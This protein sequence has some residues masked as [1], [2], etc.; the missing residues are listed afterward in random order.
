LSNASYTELNTT[1]AATVAANM[2]SNDFA[3][4]TDAQIATTVLTNL[5]LTTIAGLDNWVA[6]QLTAAGSTAAAK[7]A[8]LVSML[9][10]Y[11]MMTADA[12]YGASATSFNAKTEASLVKSQTTGTKSGSFATADVVALSTDPFVLTTGTDVADTVSATRGTLNS[13]F[14]FT[15]GNDT[16]NASIG[17]LNAADVLLDN[18]STDADVLNVTLN[19]DAGEFTAQSIETIAVNAAA[20]SPVIDMTKVFGTTAVTVSGNVA[21]Q[22]KDMDASIAGLTISASNYSK[23]LTVTP[24]TLVGTTALSTAETVNIKISGATF[25]TTTATQSA[26]VI[27]AGA[28]GTLET[29]N[30][31]SDGTAV[32]TFSLAT[33]ANGALGTVNL[34]G[35][36]DATV[37]VT[38]ADITGVTVAG[39]ANTANT[40]LVIDRH[41]VT[42]TPTNLGNVSGI[43][44]IQFRDSTV[45]TDAYVA[46][47]LLSGSSVELISTFASVTGNVLDVAGSAAGAAD[48]LTLTLDH[49]TAN[50]IVAGG[51]V[52]MQN[53]ETVNLGS[54]G[55][56]TVLI[57][58]GN[59]LTYKGDATTI[60]VSGDTAFDFTF[61]VDTPT[62]GSRTTVVNASTMTGTATVKLNGSNDTNTTNLYTITGT[63]NSDT[64]LGGAGVNNLTGGAGNDSITGG[65]SND[66]ISGG[67][68]NDNITATAGIDSLSGGTGNDTL[69]VPVAAAATAAV[70]EVQALTAVATG[71]PATAGNYLINVN[72]TTVA[73]GIDADATIAEF[74][75]AAATAINN[76]AG[77]AAGNYTATAALGVATITFAA[78]LGN[79]AAT[80]INVIDGTAGSVQLIGTATNKLTVTST[81]TDGTTAGTVDVAYS[82]FAAGDLID[83]AALTGL[84]AG[85]YYEG[86]I[87]SMTAGTD[88]GLVVIT[89]QAYALSTTVESTINTKLTNAVTTDQIFVYLDSALG[90]AVA[91]YDSDIS[92]NATLNQII[93]FTG[94]TTLAQ[95][96]AAFGDTGTSFI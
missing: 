19:A 74:A 69:V 38:H 82:D 5:S 17:T 10:D 16:I 14:K 61:N 12:T 79:V 54:K 3:G 53:I 44:K 50:T 68:G 35:G 65:A 39:A 34:L 94:I 55:S 18:S 58:A 90:H 72:G 83:K 47:G 92:G 33:G 24:A 71:T 23:T 41:G 29:L 48:S 25:G 27:S 62:T 32:N 56:D 63:A 89:D 8:K 9:N 26:L 13:T 37:R 36:A 95:L 85:G 66:V 75:L 64:L 45:G 77:A 76:T 1:A 84:A 6:A 78:S 80:T 88:Y 42:T 86:A 73:V 57:A 46:N 4:K 49:A 93:T 60:N 21:A 31:T 70:A 52:D 51:T 59:T 30:I 2:L 7:G 15:S 43:D 91:V 20:G 28:A 87:D 67:D 11:A 40:T 22:I 96:A 81:S